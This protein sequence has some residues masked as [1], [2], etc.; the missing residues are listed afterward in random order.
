MN[1]ELLDSLPPVTNFNNFFT[2]LHRHIS[3][4]TANFHDV[5]K[6]NQKAAAVENLRDKNPK[7]DPFIS[8][9]QHFQ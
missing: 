9:V 6:R 3:C 4:S 7:L 1:R 2:W 8:V 5:L